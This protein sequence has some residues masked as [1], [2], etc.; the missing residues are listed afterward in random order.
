MTSEYR[1]YINMA[2]HR[3]DADYEIIRAIKDT[4]GKQNFFELAKQK[5]YRLFGKQ[6]TPSIMNEDSGELDLGGY[7]NAIDM[8]LLQ[9]V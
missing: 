6:Y 4:F 8:A 7:G 9:R 1:Q 5:A 2:I 3:G